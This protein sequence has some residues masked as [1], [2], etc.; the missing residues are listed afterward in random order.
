MGRVSNVKTNLGYLGDTYQ[1][2]L[3]KYFIE[4]TKFF[5]SLV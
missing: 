1:E 4:T 3:V 5:I 2:L